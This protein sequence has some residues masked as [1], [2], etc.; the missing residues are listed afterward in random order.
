MVGASAYVRDEAGRILL[1]RRA[2]D[3]NWTLP[4]GAMELGERVDRTVE[5]EVYEETGLLVEP[6]RLVGIYSGPSF[7][8]TYPNGDQV[9][10][11]TNFFRCRVAGGALQPDGKEITEARFFAPDQLPALT[12]R[13]QIRITDALIGQEGAVWT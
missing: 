3:G 4:A 13:H 12:A 8:H 11:V 7:F 2:D 1:V 10:V 9:H 6:D 5:R